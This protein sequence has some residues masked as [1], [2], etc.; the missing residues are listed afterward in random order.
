MYS[1][2]ASF[3]LKGYLWKTGAKAQG[4]RALAHKHKDLSLNSQKPCKI[5]EWR[6]FKGRK[7]TEEM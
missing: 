6:G 7:E 4:I 5:G 1:V 2:Q 3:K